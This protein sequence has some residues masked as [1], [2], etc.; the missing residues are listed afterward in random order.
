MPTKPL[1]R[2]M[3]RAPLTPMDILNITEK[4][5]PYFCDG[6]PIMFAKKYTSNDAKRVPTKTTPELILYVR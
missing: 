2:A 6:L 4:G 3:Y 1:S 5:S